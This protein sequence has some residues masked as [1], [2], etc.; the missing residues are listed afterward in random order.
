VKTKL[1]VGVLLVLCFTLAGALYAT[2]APNGPPT[3]TQLNVEIAVLKVKMKRLEA[4]LRQDEFRLAVGECSRDQ[5]FYL[6]DLV[7]S[8]KPLPDR[9]HIPACA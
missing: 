5:L 9:D 4:R 8:G 3:R 2:A 7:R 6:F 1:V